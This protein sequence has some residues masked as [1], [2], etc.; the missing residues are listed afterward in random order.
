MNP[1]AA[2]TSLPNNDERRKRRSLSCT[3]LQPSELF[4][5]AV[6]PRFDTSYCV[7]RRSGVHSNS[8]QLL[9][10]GVSGAELWSDVRLPIQCEEPHGS[11]R[12]ARYAGIRHAPAATCKI[13]A[14]MSANTSKSTGLVSYNMERMN[15]AAT[16]PPTMP[17]ASP[18]NAGRSPSTSTRL[19][20]C[21]CCAQVRSEFRFPTCAEKRRKKHSEQTHGG[22]HE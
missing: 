18:L 2:S 21:C 6:Q 20:T 15:L 5:H 12:E 9:L 11:R 14:N 22:E 19:I 16:K 17:G 4:G 3:G 8:C 1:L 7:A 10:A 13:T